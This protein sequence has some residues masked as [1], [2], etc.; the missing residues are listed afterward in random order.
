MIKSKPERLCFEVQKL[1]DLCYT[2]T[3]NIH[4][5]KDDITETNLLRSCNQ[6]LKQMLI[7]LKIETEVGENENDTVLSEIHKRLLS[8]E[9]NVLGT[10]T[11][12]SQGTTIELLIDQCTHIRT[13]ME[14]TSNCNLL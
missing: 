7:D 10:R 3:E 12:S 11:V 8:F 6:C 2:D 5:E 1:K 4:K 13:R 9:A 14:A